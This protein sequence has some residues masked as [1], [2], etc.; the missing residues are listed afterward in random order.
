MFILWCFVKIYK[1]T[2]LYKDMYD[3]NYYYF[4]CMFCI[5]LSLIRLYLQCCTGNHQMINVRWSVYV[6]W[7]ATNRISN[8]CLSSKYCCWWIISVLNSQDNVVFAVLL[9]NV[10]PH[11]SR[12]LIIYRMNHRS[13]EFWKIRKWFGYLDST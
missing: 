5:H 1:Y 10:D 11:L 3:M 13:D 4:L 6:L 12:A 9:Y 7:W 2:C 8:C